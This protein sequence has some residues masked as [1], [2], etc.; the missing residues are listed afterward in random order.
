MAMG[1]VVFFG[2]GFGGG[3]EDLQFENCCLSILVH[4]LS[5][6]FKSRG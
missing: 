5:A 3:G 4:S 6:S 2:G 1:Y